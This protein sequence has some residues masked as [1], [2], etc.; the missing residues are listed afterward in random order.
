MSGAMRKMGVYLG[1]L[2]DADGQYVDSPYAVVGTY[3]EPVA[4]G[5]EQA[6]RQVSSISE[7]RRRHV[8]HRQSPR[9]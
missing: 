7:R 2:E 8:A 9:Q 5:P 6:A 4:R 3:D 1:L